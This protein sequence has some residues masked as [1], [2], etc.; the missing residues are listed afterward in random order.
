MADKAERKGRGCLFYGG[1]TMVLILIG[2]LLGI[3][4]GIR[5]NIRMAIETYTA[6]APA[7]IP[8][9]Q[10]TAAEQERVAKSISDRTEALLES[11]GPGELELNETELNVLLG[12]SPELKRFQNHIYID[13]EGEKLQAHLSVPLEQFGPWRE[14][15]KRVGKADY[16]KRYLNGLAALNVGVTNG[17]LH[18]GLAELTV[19]GQALPEEFSKRI[20]PHNFAAEVRRDA[21]FNKAVERIESVGVQDGKLKVRFKPSA[22]TMPPPPA[23]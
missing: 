14:L 21:E 19:N 16:G 11:T 1:I 17:V 18:V 9:L 10:L 13:P 22:S 23:R 8:T 15:T 5:K 3:Y 2:V 4:F 7:Q 12:A 6:T 20:R